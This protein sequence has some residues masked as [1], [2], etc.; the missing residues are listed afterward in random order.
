M[1]LRILPPEQYPNTRHLIAPDACGAVYPLSVIEGTQ[2]GTVYT[3]DTGRAVLIWHCCG[4]AFLF[5]A[6]DRAFLAECAEIMRHPVPYTRMLLFAPDAETAAFFRKTDGFL[7][8]RRLFFRYPVSTQPQTTIPAVRITADILTQ[9]HGKITPAFSWQTAA[10][11]LAN[12]CGFCVMQDGVPAA[13]SFSAAVSDT[14]I[15]IGVETLASYRRRGFAFAAAAAMIQAALSQGKVPVW[16]CHAQ[17]TGSQKL[18][19]G[20]GFVP[21]GECLTV[22]RTE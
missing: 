10:D 11:F 7:P 9:I 12:G 2:S 22:K 14:E 3:D 19:A 15:D 17:N 1:S 13:W 18:A 6:Y 4:F 16:A 8:E 5:G 21:C 20:L